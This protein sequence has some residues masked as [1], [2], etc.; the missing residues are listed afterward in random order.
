V[1][2]KPGGVWGRCLGIEV[3]GAA[4][5]AE[6]VGIT[7][8]EAVQAWAVGLWGSLAKVVGARGGRGVPGRRQHQERWH[9]VAG[10]KAWA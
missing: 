5:G 6:F 9:R 1:A 7:G 10:R 3:E 8:I 2:G 4:S